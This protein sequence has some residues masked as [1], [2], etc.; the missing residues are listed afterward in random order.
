M[1]CLHSCLLCH[2]KLWKG[3]H[4]LLNALESFSACKQKDVTFKIFWEMSTSWD[5][6]AADSMTNS[7]IRCNETRERRWRSLVRL[8][9][10]GACCQRRQLFAAKGK[11]RICYINNWDSNS[12]IRLLEN[13]K[14][15]MMIWPYGKLH[16][17]PHSSALFLLW[18]WILDTTH[19][20]S[21]K[22]APTW[23]FPL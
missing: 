11:N 10:E 14:K 4:K 16:L 8:T 13:N 6:D 12:S 1:I 7:W 9:K 22:L 23:A 20:D 2:F 5:S 17:I 21:H 19:F 18:T 3:D 15:M